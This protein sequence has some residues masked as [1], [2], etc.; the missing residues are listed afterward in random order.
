MRRPLL[1]AL[2]LAVGCRGH[3]TINFLQPARV[4]INP[5]IQV[6]APLD[7]AREGLSGQSLDTLVEILAASER[8]RVIEPPA[9]DRAFAAHPAMVGL[10]VGRE[11]AR[12]VCDDTGAQGLVVLES[13]HAE[14]SWSEVQK[15]VEHTFTEEYTEGGEV[16]TR[17]VKEQYTV[18]VATLHLNT[19]AFFSTYDCN[20]RILDSFEAISHQEVSAEGPTPAEARAAIRDQ[21]ALHFAAAR[22]V[23]ERYAHRIAPLPSSVER[24][25]YKGGALR[26]GALSAAAG[27]WEKASERWQAAAKATEGKARGKA[28][29]DLAVAAEAAGDLSTA[30]DFAERA[31]TLLR[32]GASA[33]YLAAL[34]KRAKQQQRVDRQLGG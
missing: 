9:A 26:E 4:T 1:I 16:K 33:R 24:A 30:L 31:D 11:V 17:E 12:G 2:A 25:F 20:G 32:S 15:D 5:E 21:N 6:L 28:L 22:E 8:Y 3:V 27:D 13:W 34:K 7:R 18:F 14:P 29:W 23:A 10:P 19:P